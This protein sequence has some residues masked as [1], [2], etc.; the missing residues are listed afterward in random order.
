MS[1]EESSPAYNSKVLEFKP[2]NE[3]VEIVFMFQIL[4]FKRGLWNFI[5]F[6]LAEHIEES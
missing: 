3:Y 6:G 4:S 2:S 5:E 1:K